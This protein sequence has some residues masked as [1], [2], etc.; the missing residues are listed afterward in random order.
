MSERPRGSGRASRHP[1]RRRGPGPGAIVVGL[2]AV[3]GTGLG[4]WAWSVGWEESLR[5]WFAP[6]ETLPPAPSRQYP[7]LEALPATSMA[8]WTEDER[9]IRAVED[10][11]RGA[12]LLRETLEWHREEGGD[13]F[14]FRAQVREA[15]G[16]LRGALE[17]LHSLRADWEQ[18]PTALLDIDQAIRRYEQGLDRG[19]K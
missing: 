2:L 7:R 17:E 6:A 1:R 19:R 4:V 5:R 3:A 9:W 13:P 8:P 12:V 18:N 16:L 11:E 14:R 10:G 15:E